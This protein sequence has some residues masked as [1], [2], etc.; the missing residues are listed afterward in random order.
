M[1]KHLITGL[2]IWVP[3]VITVWVLHTVINTLDQSLLLIP[4]QWHPDTLLGFHVWG[5]GTALA[6][7]AVLVTGMIA[8]NLLGQRLVRLWEHA[9][10]RIPVVRQIYT[11]VKQ[12]SDTLLGPSGQAFRKAVLVEYPRQGS[13]TIAFVTGHPSGELQC[14]LPDDMVNVYVPTTPNPTSG[15]FLM[16]PRSAMRELEMP[17]DAALKHIISMGSLANDDSGSGAHPSG[18]DGVT[19]QP[20]TT[21]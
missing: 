18:T 11:S 5:L 15:F 8:S 3:L 10:G 17:V 9:L 13:W 21:T 6:F 7:L 1:K 4:S 20:T 2:L 16:M 19:T 12:V 14:H